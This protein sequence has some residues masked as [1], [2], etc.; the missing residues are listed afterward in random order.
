VCVDVNIY[1]R[2]H[3]LKKS[4][5]IQSDTSKVERSGEKKKKPELPSKCSPLS[6]VVDISEPI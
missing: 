2:R 4:I 5:H 1:E 6:R 3:M